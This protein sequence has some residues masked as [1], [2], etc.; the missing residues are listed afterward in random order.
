[1]IKNKKIKNY[2]IGACII[3]NTV[4]MAAFADTN[5]GKS[6]AL[7]QGEKIDK[8]AVMEIKPAPANSPEEELM[9]KT[10]ML[11][12][13][14]ND[15]I[16][17][18]QS[19][20]DRYLFEE[21]AKEIEQKGFMVTHTV[22]VGNQVEIGIKPYDQAK[23]DYLYEIFGKDTIMVVSGEAAELM[24]VSTMAPEAAADTVAENNDSK[25]VSF[26]ES[27]WTWIKN[28]F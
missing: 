3:A 19:E 5:A 18:K 9:Y 4:S 17:E 7:P 11:T 28:I 6:P 2:I 14:E 21:H 24:A 13:T 20:I 8:A 23:A 1:M 12:A 25:I 26:F 16:I 22:P 27:I 15:P 10:Q